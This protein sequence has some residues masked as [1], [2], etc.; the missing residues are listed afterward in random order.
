[1]P[2]APE[3]LGEFRDIHP[4]LVGNRPAPAHPPA[5]PRSTSTPSHILNLQRPI[6]HPS[7]PARWA[8]GL[9]KTLFRTIITASR[10]SQCNPS[11]AIA[12]AR[13]E[14]FRTLVLDMSTKDRDRYQPSP[15]SVARCHAHRPGRAL[16]YW[17]PSG[18]TRDPGTNTTRSLSSERSIARAPTT[19]SPRRRQCRPAFP[20]PVLLR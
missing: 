5:V 10:P 8:S 18:I 19:S 3:L 13:G 9:R 17:K 20:H 6:D 15:P 14:P 12:R 16:E 4:A 7:Y 11:D 2:A 1:M